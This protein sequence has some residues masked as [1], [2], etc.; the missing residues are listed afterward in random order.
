MRETPGATP[1]VLL[2]AGANGA[3]KSTV[4]P[5]LMRELGIRACLNADEIA[6]GLNP[7]DPAA[8][9][10]AAGR[11][12]HLRMEVLRE[13]RTS[14]ALET[15]LSGRSLLGQ[16]RRLER[17]GYVS[18]VAFL[19]LPSADA[20]VQRV[21]RRVALGGHEVP[22]EDIRRR[23]SRGVHNFEQIYR[24]VVPFWRVYHG[25]APRTFGRPPLIA[26]GSAAIVQTVADRSAWLAL[27]VQ[28]T[29]AMQG[30]GDER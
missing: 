11:E 28:A 1:Q 4:A 22:E 29:E 13:R 30:G 16:L 21:R 12:M 17:S 15:T 26:S 25:A 5:Q 3:G 8:A 27:R 19:W 23:H 7:A 18:R 20:A 9:A 10:V 2:I 24:L 6:R 14:F